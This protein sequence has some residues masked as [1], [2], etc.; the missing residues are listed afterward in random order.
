MGREASNNNCRE[1]KFVAQV[2]R[3]SDHDVRRTRA[4]LLGTGIFLAAKRLRLPSARPYPPGACRGGL[5]LVPASFALRR[6]PIDVGLLSLGAGSHALASFVHAPQPLAF[7]LRGRALAFV[8]SLLA[9][10]GRPLA[11]VGDLLTLVGDPVSSTG[12]KFPPFQLRLA[13]G[14]G[15]FA[16]VERVRPPFR[17]RGRLETI[18]GGHSSP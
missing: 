12:L 13:S 15:I 14:N 11:V 4:N 9:F 7:A 8:C 2:I 16:L 1:P 3:Y 10:V 6:L 18:L 17:L 5:S